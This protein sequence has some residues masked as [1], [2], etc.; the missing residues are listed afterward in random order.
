[1][2]AIL[3]GVRQNLKAVSID[4][5]LVANVVKQC[6]NCLLAAFI[7]PFGG[8]LFRYTAAIEESVETEMVSQCVIYYCPS[9]SRIALKSSV[10]IFQHMDS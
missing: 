5:Y 3:P 2:I 7:S 8:S 10:V 4:I 9:R 1:M 6:L